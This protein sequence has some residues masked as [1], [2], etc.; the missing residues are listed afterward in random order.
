[1]VSDF[2]PLGEAKREPTDSEFACWNLGFRDDGVKKICPDDG[3]LLTKTARSKW[4]HG[5]FGALPNCSNRNNSATGERPR[6]SRSPT[7]RR[8]GRDRSRLP[9]R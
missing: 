3:Q 9:K 5:D 1:M 7:D 2:D 8:G 4:R 6:N